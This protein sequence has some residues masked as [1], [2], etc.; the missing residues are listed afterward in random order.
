[1]GK[2]QGANMATVWKEHRISEGLFSVLF[3]PTDRDLVISEWISKAPYKKRKIRKEL[4]KKIACKSFDIAL[5]KT[6]K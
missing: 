2:I 5:F 3:V 1:M 6:L 4:F